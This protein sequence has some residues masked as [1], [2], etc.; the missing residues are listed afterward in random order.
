MR[1]DAYV[2]ERRRR[3]RKRRIYGFGALAIFAAY[4]VFWGAF[5]AVTKSPLLRVRNITIEGASAVSDQAIMD[6]LQASIIRKGDAVNAPNSGPKAFLGFKNMLV[7]PGSLPSAT[8]AMI[9]RLAG[10]A[11]AR[12]FF[13]DTVTVAVTERQP[14][15]IWCLMNAPGGERCYW[16]D[17]SGTAFETAGDTQGSAIVV[18][19]DYSQTNLAINGP[20]LPEEFIPNLI[21]IVDALKQSGLN[22]SEVALH[23]LSLQQIDVATV[24]GPTVSFSLRFPANDDV[25]VLESLMARPDF[26]KLQYIDF[27]VPNRAYYK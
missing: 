2:S 6:L 22:V 8:V 14:F 27:T 25:P 15:A 5:A 17:R 20:V 26:A 24:N 4:G 9:P 7:W 21:S 10:V 16:F 18:F 11:I 23:D 12:N 19:H 13:F 1:I 3:Q